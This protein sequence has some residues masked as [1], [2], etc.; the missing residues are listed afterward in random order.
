MTV[1]EAQKRLRVNEIK[2]KIY[3]EE[4]NEKLHFLMGY[5]NR[6]KANVERGKDIENRV[7]RR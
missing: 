7:K 4:T 5:E 3:E 1:K 2:K 6:I